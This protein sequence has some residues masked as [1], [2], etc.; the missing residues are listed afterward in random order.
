MPANIDS[1]NLHYHFLHY[2]GDSFNFNFNYLN[3]NG[4]AISITGCTAEMHIRRSP[5][6]TNLIGLIKGDYPNGAFGG[7]GDTEFG[8]TAGVTSGTGGIRLELNGITGAVD[9]TID[10]DTTA[11]FPAARH[12]YDL[13]I[14][15][16]DG[17]KLV[18]LSGTFE[19]SKQTTR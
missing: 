10:G 9:I 6:S 7:S 13:Q 1:I 12:F 4:S 15:K 16:T 3:A 2:Q 19:I 14:E 11:K 17:E 18:I 5:E 8:Y